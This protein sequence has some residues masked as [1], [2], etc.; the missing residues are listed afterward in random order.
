MNKCGILKLFMKLSEQ[1]LERKYFVIFFFIIY[2]YLFC[3]TSCG[4]VLKLRFEDGTISFLDIIALNH[5]FDSLHT[6]TGM[7]M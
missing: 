2:F 5:S 7:Y 3:D 1:G 4:F 6:L